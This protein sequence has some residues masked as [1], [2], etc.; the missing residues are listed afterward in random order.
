MSLIVGSLPPGTMAL[1]PGCLI[2]SK[3]D[4]SPLKAKRSPKLRMAAANG[5]SMPKLTY[6]HLRRET[7][8]GLGEL[9]STLPMVPA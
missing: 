8:V 1:L 4:V 7:Q 3:L 9:L 6:W 2:V 5:L